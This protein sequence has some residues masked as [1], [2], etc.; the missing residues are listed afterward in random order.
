VGVGGHVNPADAGPDVVGAALARELCEELHLPA[1]WRARIAGFV[2]DDATP[3]GSVHFGVVAVVDP[4]AG[5]VRVREADTMS[6]TFVPRG[7]LLRLHAR[8]RDSFEGWS[9]LLLDRLDEVLA[10]ARP[11][12]SSSTTRSTTPTSTT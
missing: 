4:G 3:V 1:G 11:R 9:A 5:D 7:D 2:N 12:A 10:W 8:E 6:G